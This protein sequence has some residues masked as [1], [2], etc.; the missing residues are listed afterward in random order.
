MKQRRLCNKILKTM[1][2]LKERRSVQFTY[3]YFHQIQI[4]KKSTQN[5]W[6]NV[7]GS[8]FSIKN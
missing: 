6:T 1:R 7:L 3:L 2:V 4:V 8:L 5:G